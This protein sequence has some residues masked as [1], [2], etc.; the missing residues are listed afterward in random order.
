MILT[1]VILLCFVQFNDFKITLK[2]APF[3][4]SF[5]I[6]TFYYLF[7]FSISSFKLIGESFLLFLV[8]LLSYYLYQIDL[9]TKNRKKIQTQYT[10]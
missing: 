1:G 7:Y 9:F 3:I 8:P 10:D 6:L 2:N 5:V 4:A